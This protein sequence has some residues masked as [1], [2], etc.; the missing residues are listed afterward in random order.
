MVI[1]HYFTLF[2]I[3]HFLSL[4]FEM[5]SLHLEQ[6]VSPFGGGLDV[7]VNSFLLKYRQSIPHIMKLCG[8]TFD[9]R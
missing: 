4:V 9:R 2:S 5:L 6:E 1:R 8:G 3:Y 7:L